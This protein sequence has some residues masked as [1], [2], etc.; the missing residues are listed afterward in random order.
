MKEEEEKKTISS[1]NARKNPWKRIRIS[2]LLIYIFITDKTEEAKGSSSSD[3]D[4]LE[5]GGKSVCTRSLSRMCVCARSSWTAC[6]K[7]WRS[8]SDRVYVS[9]GKHAVYAVERVRKK[10]EVC[11]VCAVYGLVHLK[12]NFV[13]TKEYRSIVT[14]FN[15]YKHKPQNKQTFL[16]THTQPII[17]SAVAMTDG[18]GESENE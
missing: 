3:G 2:N 4:S 17:N 16:H 14:G 10:W 15:A 5:S 9:V 7:L 8:E 18:D 12:C 6:A 1:A 11:R 13:S